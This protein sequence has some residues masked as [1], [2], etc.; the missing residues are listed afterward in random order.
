MRDARCAMF[1]LCATGYCKVVHALHL[2]YVRVL[3]TLLFM[4]RVL[5]GFPST[6]AV[7]WAW[8]VC[9]SSRLLLRLQAKF[10]IDDQRG[11]AVYSLLCSC[12]G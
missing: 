9:A 1:G 3:N 10:H 12:W 8:I 6:T 4:Y 11:Q 7:Q 2:R 5:G